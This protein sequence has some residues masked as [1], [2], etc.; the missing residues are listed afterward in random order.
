MSTTSRSCV[1]VGSLCLGFVFLNRFR[2]FTIQQVNHKIKRFL[3][4]FVHIDTIWRFA[5]IRSPS[6]GSFVCCFREF[7]SKSG[8]F[9]PGSAAYGFAGRVKQAVLGCQAGGVWV[10][11]Q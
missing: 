5:K 8:G 11:L 9:L 2:I 3:R 4:F 6:F 7:L 10:F 1:W